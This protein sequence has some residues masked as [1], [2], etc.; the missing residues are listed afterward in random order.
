MQAATDEVA[1]KLLNTMVADAR[2]VVTQA[3]AIGRD[4]AKVAHSL[5][6]E[7]VDT[8]LAWLNRLPKR[9]WPPEGR[10]ARQGRHFMYYPEGGKPVVG[11]I[12]RAGTIAAPPEIDDLD[13]ALTEG[14]KG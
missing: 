13:R 8:L 6:P 4:Y 12:P 7:A 10:F 9:K 5:S 14:W 3:R 11:S 1:T 2:E